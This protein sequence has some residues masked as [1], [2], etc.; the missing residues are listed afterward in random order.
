VAGNAQTKI[1]SWLH[2]CH[3]GVP[4]IHRLSVKDSTEF[5][6][7]LYLPCNAK[8]AIKAFTSLNQEIAQGRV[9]IAG[10]LE[11]LLVFH[12]CYNNEDR[13]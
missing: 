3:P 7:Y 10:F 2:T 5:N 1:G 12:A 8:I 6:C 9:G 13:F 4:K 11:P